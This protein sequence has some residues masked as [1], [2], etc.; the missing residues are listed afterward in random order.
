MI[1]HPIHDYAALALTEM[2][3]DVSNFS[4]RQITTKMAE[5]ADVVLTM[6]KAHRDAVLELAPRQLS[7][8]FTLAEAFKLAIDFNA[9]SILDLARLRPQLRGHTISDVPDPLGHSAD[10]FAMVGTTIS[11]LLPPVLDLCRDD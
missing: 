7:R 10:Y 1:A 8:T 4:A 9:R 11:Q 5:E 6:T 3:A 2:G